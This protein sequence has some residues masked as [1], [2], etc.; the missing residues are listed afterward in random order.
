[1]NGFTGY[2]PATLE[3]FFAQVKGR[4]EKGHREYG[5]E[6][7]S[8]S[9]SKLAIEIR[10]EIEDIAG[11]ASIMHGRII[12]LAQ[13]TRLAEAES[14]ELDRRIEAQKAHLAHLEAL[15]ARE[16]PED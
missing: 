15:S 7:F 14:A 12:R 16:V 13:K 8:K 11:W 3:S 9:P 4:M 2:E 1:M 5:D 6:S 10:E